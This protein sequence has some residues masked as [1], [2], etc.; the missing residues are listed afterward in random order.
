MRE[1]VFVF[2]Q[3]FEARTSHEVKSHRFVTFKPLQYVP[4]YINGPDLYSL[5]Y[6]DLTYTAQ[7]RIAETKL[8]GV[9]L[10]GQSLNSKSGQIPYSRGVFRGYYGGNRPK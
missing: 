5:K 9:K 6:M 7:V 8:G 4:P 2:A 10:R 1:I 3:K